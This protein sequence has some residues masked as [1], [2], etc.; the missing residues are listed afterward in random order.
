MSSCL[1]KYAII[2]LSALNKQQS[3]NIFPQI[4][5]SLW[6]TCN[7]IYH[8]L[9][10]NTF[11]QLDLIQLK[12]RLSVIFHVITIQVFSK[13]S[14]ISLQSTCLGMHCK[15]AYKYIVENSIIVIMP[16]N[17]IELRCVLYT[18]MI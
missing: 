2:L 8:Q 13:S 15:I 4:F 14:F 11:K 9:N 12:I 1:Y 6:I 3:D 5:M 17:M 16:W 10:S 18:N 7:F